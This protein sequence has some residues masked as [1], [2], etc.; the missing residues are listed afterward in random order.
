M[1]IHVTGLQWGP[2]R[3]P[4]IRDIS[5]TVDSGRV[6]GIVG[7]NGAGKSSLLRCLAGLQRPSAGT[8][9][10]DDLELFRLPVKERATLVAFV[11]Q[12]AHTDADLTVREVVELGRIPHRRRLSNPSGED[13]PIIDA[14]IRQVGLIEYENRS[15]AT[16]SGGERQR[17][18]LAKALAQQPKVLILDE[19]TNHLDVKHQFDLM[20]HLAHADPT[21]IVALHD[22]RMAATYCDEII[23]LDKGKLLIHE[24]P[25]RALT[26][27]AFATFSTSR[28]SMYPKAPATN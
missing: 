28:P 3:T 26:P 12:N 15:W 24:A 11:E 17:A 19:P 27:S 13:D 25:N 8:V 4:I 21:V 6:V 16:L 1:R 22:L 5:F 2:G 23:V 18:Y 7:P 20:H 10:Y 14:S 9:A